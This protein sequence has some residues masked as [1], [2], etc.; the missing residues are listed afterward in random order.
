M[1][2]NIPSYS[3]RHL[4]GRSHITARQC[5]VCPFH[6]FVPKFYHFAEAVN[7]GFE[8][9]VVLSYEFFGVKKEGASGVETTYSG[10]NGLAFLIKFASVLFEYEH[11]K[12]IA[13]P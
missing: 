4:R 2:V 7:F 11:L 6:T 5:W 13:K 8:M 3:I 9:R 10:N 1:V 12:L